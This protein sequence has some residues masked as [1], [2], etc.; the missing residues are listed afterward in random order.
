MTFKATLGI[1]DSQNLH[2]IHIIWECSKDLKFHISKFNYC[3]LKPPSLTSAAL[4]LYPHKRVI[5]IESWK[6]RDT[7][8]GGQFKEIREF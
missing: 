6:Q 2:W 5:Y 4:Q 3:T 1:H 7:G 8:G